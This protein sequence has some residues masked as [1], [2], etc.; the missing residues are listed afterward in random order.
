MEVQLEAAG[1]LL[2]QLKVRIPAENVA[3]AVDQRL[4]Q[5][6]SRAKIPG[7]RP[8]KAPF[9]VIQQQY[10]ASARM[11]AVSDLV[12][13]SYPEAL[14][15]AGVNPAGM[16][17]IDI[18]AETEG[19]PLE[20]VASF[21]V[22]PEIVLQGLGALAIE[23]PVVNIQDSDIDKLV[24]NLR[25]GRRELE[26]VSRA[27][28]AG[29]LVNIDF[30]GKLDGVAF[31]G[32][33]GDK[34]EFEIGAGQFLPDLENGIVG[35]AAGESFVVPVSF[36]ENYQSEELKGKTAHFDVTVNE[37]KGAKLPDVDD[38]E[39][40]KAHNV[41]SAAA[42][43][44]KG[45]KALENE[46]DKAIRG[47]LKS[48]ALEQLLSQNPIDVPAALIEQEVPRLREDAAQRMNL[49]NLPA[50]K[51]D[52][53]LPASLFEQTARRRVALGLLIGEVIKERAIK[54]DP[55]RVDKALDDMA[56]DYEQPEEVKQY[57]RSNAQMMQSLSAVVLEDQVV[58]SLLDGITPTEQPMSLE[59][60]LNP[61]AQA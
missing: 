59:Q 20:Y 22:Y 16:P 32:G 8:G 60:L 7:F 56:A 31:Q 26:V 54:L 4:K 12:Q 51:R 25:K 15:K 38:A 49:R 14:G 57:Y 48:Q 36:P 27:A 58:E 3:K 33:K 42:L 44:D 6:S 9:K 24:D 47:R 50:E 52:E 29:D 21:E 19:Q 28:A 34:V 17:K 55:A 2:R 5:M 30:D 18:T 40:L 61:Q 46:R 43:R 10:G 39:F 41:D 11:D 45:L 23:K 1:G 53:L 35:H 13:K 37:V